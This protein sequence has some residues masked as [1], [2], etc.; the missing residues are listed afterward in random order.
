LAGAPTVITGIAA[1]ALF[2]EHLAAAWF[3][4]EGGLEAQGV[5]K[6]AGTAATASDPRKFLITMTRCPP[7]HG[8][9]AA[10]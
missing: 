10:H 1:A 3:S 9:V 4:V 8:E 7:R 2:G 5:G 6:A